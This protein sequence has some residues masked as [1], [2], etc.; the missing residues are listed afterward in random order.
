MPSRLTPAMNQAL[1]TT[2]APFGRA[3]ADLKPFRR[4]FA[5]ETLWKPLDDGWELKAPP[6]DHPG[7]ALA[8]PEKLFEHHA[9]LFTPDLKPFSEVDETYTRE[10]L[11]F[12]PPP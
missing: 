12:G 1:E 2:D 6:P 5:A 4:T 9:L 7:E 3:V 10:V 11:S 8:I